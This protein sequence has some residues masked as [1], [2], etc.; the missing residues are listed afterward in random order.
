MQDYVAPRALEAAEIPE[1]VAQYGRGARHA[2]EAGFDGVELHGANGY[3]VD[4]FLRD[5]TNHRSDAWG[6][7]VAKRAR[8]LLE[9]V[10]AL[11][12]VWR[13][14]RVGVRLSPSGTF[15]DMKDSNPLETFTHAVRELNQL[16]VGYLHLIEAGEADLR[17]GG[18]A[19]PTEALRPLFSRTL[20]VNGDY[21]RARAGAAIGEGRTD[22]VSFGRLFLANPDL[23]QRLRTGAALNPA[24]PSTF[25]GGDEKGYTD[26]PALAS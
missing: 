16:E 25:Y 20:I 18:R 2:L 13:P 5:G 11:V 15:N 10:Q 7:P 24:D 6:G 17:H 1:I 22:L 3:L 23:P 19:V 12:A 4:Q 21:D 26:Y 9:V 14:E 8:F